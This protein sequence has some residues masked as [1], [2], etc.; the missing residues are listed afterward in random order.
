MQELA[1]GKIPPQAG[2]LAV[3]TGGTSGLGFETA[4]KLA[5]GC[6]DVILAGRDESKGREALGRLRPLAPHALVRFEVLDLA[7]QDSVAA[8]AQRLAK[9]NRPVDL[10]INNANVMALPKREVT[11]D[12]FEMQLATNY[13]GHFALTGR[14]LPLLRQGRRSRVVQVSSLAHRYG[15]IHFDDLHGERSYGPWAAYCQSK[16]AALVF[17]LELQRRSGLYGWGLHSNAVHPGY[18]KPGLV[19][20]APGKRTLWTWLGRGLGEF[21][22]HSVADGAQSALLAATS[23]DAEPGAYYGP[24]GFLELAGHP[25]HAVVAKRAR[26]RDL[27]KR[28]WEVS[29][30]LTGVHWPVG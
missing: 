28:L 16:L 14:L 10:L 6:V 1:T 27:A 8:F 18:S 9:R 15:S 12:G 7:R 2:R 22:G 19:E 21:V 20:N 26:D 30:Q 11:A 25:A 13:L 24:R 3:V 17:A 29:E 23:P 5:Q 4:L